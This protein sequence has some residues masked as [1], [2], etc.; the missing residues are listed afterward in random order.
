MERWWVAK[1]QWAMPLLERDSTPPLSNGLRVQRGQ[2]RREKLKSMKIKKTQPSQRQFSII[3]GY[4]DNGALLVGPALFQMEHFCHFQTWSKIRNL[5]GRVILEWME[6]M[7]HRK[8]RETKQQPNMLPCPSVPGCCLV[9]FHFLCDIH[10]VGLAPLSS[11]KCSKP[12]KK[13]KKGRK[14]GRIEEGGVRARV[15]VLRAKTGTILPYVLAL[16]AAAAAPFH[17]GKGQVKEAGAA[18]GDP[19]IMCGGCR[20]HSAHQSGTNTRREEDGEEENEERLFTCGE[21]NRSMSSV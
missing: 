17:C 11:P 8:R 5:S 9:S 1:S 12:S 15:R 14:A 4:F 20:I 16:S 2:R 13:V 10:C 19:L 7:S 21:A 18:A 6:S 3:F